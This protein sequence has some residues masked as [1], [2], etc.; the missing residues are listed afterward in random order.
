MIAQRLSS[1]LFP[2]LRSGLVI[3]AGFWKAFGLLLVKFLTHAVTDVPVLVGGAA[4]VW[5][6]HF[7]GMNVPIGVPL[8]WIAGG[9][10]LIVFVA[11]SVKPLR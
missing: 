11:V 4:V 5:G 7:F 8:A 1:S 9:A 2:I 6:I 10:L 3:L